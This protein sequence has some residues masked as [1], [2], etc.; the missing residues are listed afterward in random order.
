MSVVL[1]V[2]CDRCAM[3]FLGS[4]R[5]L[6]AT[7]AETQPYGW[8]VED[9]R[10]SVCPYCLYLVEVHALAVDLAEALGRSVARD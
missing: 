3:T 7:I 1:A 10:E 4:S 8:L 6:D 5:D 9:G 2:I